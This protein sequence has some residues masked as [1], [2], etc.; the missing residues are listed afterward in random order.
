MFPFT[1]SPR[2]IPSFA[3]LWSFGFLWL[4]LFAFLRLVRFDFS[5]RKSP[6]MNQFCK[7]R[8]VF[9][10]WVN[11]LLRGVQALLILLLVSSVVSSGVAGCLI[12]PLVWQGVKSRFSI[13]LINV[14]QILIL[15]WESWT[16]SK[17]L[18]WKAIT[19]KGSVFWVLHLWWTKKWIWKCLHIFSR[20]SEN[21]LKAGCAQGAGF[22]LPGRLCCACDEGP[23]ERQPLMGALNL[24]G[25]QPL[26]GALNFKAQI[27]RLWN[28]KENEALMEPVNVDEVSEGDGAFNVSWAYHSG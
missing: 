7:I 15:W 20:M 2:L 27:S 26:M 14:A 24:G 23:G 5:F 22:L 18:T 6:Q 17:R 28:K 3:I 16:L 9:E 13:S 1:W 4:V 8:C 21:T 10:V 19:I 12:L 25:R 11:D